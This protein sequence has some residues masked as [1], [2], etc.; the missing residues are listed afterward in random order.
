[1]E[2]TKT[3]LLDTLQLAVIS[4]TVQFIRICLL[5]FLLYFIIQ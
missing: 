1:M 2:K 4:V 5:V 3:K